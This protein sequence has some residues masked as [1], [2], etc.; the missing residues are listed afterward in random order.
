MWFLW[1]GRSEAGF[2]GLELAH[3]NNFSRFWGIGTVLSCP[4]PG[5]GVI[6]TSR[7]WSEFESPTKEMVGVCALDWFM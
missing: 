3:L 7:Y 1:K 2:I 4:V 6:R 5:P